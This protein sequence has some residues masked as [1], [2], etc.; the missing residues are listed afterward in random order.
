MEI[1]HFLPTCFVLAASDVRQ[2]KNG[3]LHSDEQALIP[4]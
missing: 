4:L 2:E 3:G 1:V